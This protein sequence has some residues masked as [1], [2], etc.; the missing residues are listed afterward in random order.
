MWR[1]VTLG[2]WEKLGAWS[3]KISMRETALV[4]TMMRLDQVE[5]WLSEK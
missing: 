3:Q 5:V 4:R 2:K 1:R